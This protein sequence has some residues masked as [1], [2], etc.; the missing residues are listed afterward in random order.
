[1]ADNIGVLMSIFTQKEPNSDTARVGIW[2][3][4]RDVGNSGGVG[5]S[6]PDFGG[7]SAEVRG[8]G[9]LLRLP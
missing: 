7:R 8:S 9:E 3:E 2:I 4:I 6:D 1:M 5:E